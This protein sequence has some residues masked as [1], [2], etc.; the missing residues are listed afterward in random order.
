[1]NE[2]LIWLAFSFAVVFTFL[3]ALVSVKGYSLIR[4]RG[5]NLSRLREMQRLQKSAKTDVR[6]E[7][8]DAVIIQCKS[9]RKKWILKEADLNLS[10]NTLTLISQIAAIYHPESKNPV[11]EAR[12]GRLL[13]AFKELHNSVSTLTRMK[14]IRALTQFRLRHLYFLSRAWKRKADWQESP[15]G[16]RLSRYKLYPLIKWCWAL[17]RCMDLAYWSLKMLAYL[18]YDVVFKILLVQWYLIAGELALQVY[19]DGDEDP[20]ISSEDILRGLEDMPEEQNLLSED[21][22]EDVRSVAAASRKSI[23]L[24]LKTLKRARVREIYFL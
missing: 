2:L 21:L 20:E 5:L 24:N 1:M 23:L 6:R 7:A 11:D 14:G 8:L 16:K 19:G 22:P 15:T 3:A 10:E 18:L 9:V 13:K 12:V 4:I 17:V